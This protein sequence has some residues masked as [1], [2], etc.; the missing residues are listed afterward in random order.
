MDDDDDDDESCGCGE[1]VRRT[2]PCPFEARILGGGSSGPISG[3]LKCED[4]SKS[5]DD[6]D[7]DVVAHVVV[8]AAL[9]RVIRL[10]DDG[11][12]DVA[13][14]CRTLGHDEERRTAY[15]IRQ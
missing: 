14:S 13:A 12:V 6:D 15:T 2:T 10:D 1:N 3:R 7:D 4:D 5:D 11:P 9:R 8:V